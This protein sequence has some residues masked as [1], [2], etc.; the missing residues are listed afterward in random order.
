MKRLI[1][2]T[3]TLLFLAACASVSKRAP[4]ETKQVAP[5]PTGAPAAAP[6]TQR[7]TQP[8]RADLPDLGPAPELGN[9]VWLN[10]PGPLRLSD[11]RGRVILLDMWTF[12]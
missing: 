1:L 5:D 6:N 11:L 10:T 9:Q 8:A 2:T 3:M 12:G 7:P 4:V